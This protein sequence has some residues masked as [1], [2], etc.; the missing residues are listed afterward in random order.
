MKLR[1]GAL[2]R[3]KGDGFVFRVKQTGCRGGGALLQC[4]DAAR[5]FGWFWKEAIERDFEVV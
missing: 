4:V 2:L 1:K 3:R 5:I